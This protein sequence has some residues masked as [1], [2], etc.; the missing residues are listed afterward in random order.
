MGLKKV[1]FYIN[2]LDKGGAQRVIVNVAEALYA[3]GTEVVL[4][5][6]KKAEE[7]YTVS[8][9][10]RRV[11]S[12]ITDD[13]VTNSRV[14]NFYRRFR[15]LR[16]IWKEERPDVAVSFIGKNNFMT[17]ATAA[18]LPV[19]VAVSVRGEPTEEYYNKVMRLIA[20]HLFAF[21]DGII[22][23]TEDAKAFFPQKAQKKSVILPNPLDVAC[24]R[25]RY[26]GVREDTIVSVGRV[27]ENKNHKMII[28]AFIAN[29]DKYPKMH[30]VIYG[31]GDKRQSLLQYIKEQHMED[32]IHMPGN[33]SNVPDHIERARIFI[34]ASD[35]E[36]MPNALL[37]AM[38][39]GLAVIST[40]CPCGGPRTVI[41]H[42]ENGMLVPVR[43]TRALT[44]ALDQ[45][46]SDPQLEQSMGAK[47]YEIQQQ[48]SPEVVNE[49]W[50][51]YLEKIW[52]Q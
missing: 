29:H 22:F 47:A 8:D 40:D 9:G 44:K 2:S 36:G 51:S 12:E 10:I 13:E 23:Q 52:K 15:K 18:F 49:K 50:Q 32:Y 7:E 25:P 20:K 28:D 48:L 35:T 31:N 46:L 4:V 30:L 41:R 39:L 6:T 19:S 38:A 45:I 1:A 33:V 27:D 24:M 5:T 16:K 43:D 14:G 3:K 42:G 37:E 21:A 11:Y 34:L 26:E 17:I